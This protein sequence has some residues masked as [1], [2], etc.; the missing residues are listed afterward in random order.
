[1]KNSVS[2]DKEEK[3]NDMMSILLRDKR[4]ENQ[5]QGWDIVDW[6]FAATAF[7]ASCES[8]NKKLEPKQRR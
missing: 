2:P 8:F 3:S 7:L 4:F 5:Q 6:V 1:M